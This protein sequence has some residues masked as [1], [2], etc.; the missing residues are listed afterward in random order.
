MKKRNLWVVRSGVAV[1][2]VLLAGG[3]ALN[4]SA[5]TNAAGPDAAADESF[6]ADTPEEAELASAPARPISTAK[7]LPPDLKLTP[8]AAEVARLV[9]SG[10]DAGVVRAFVTNSASTF[11]LG[12]DEI[13]YLNDIGV[14]GNI[15][16]AM[17]ERDKALQGLSAGQPGAYAPQPAEAMPAAETPPE[18]AP[19]PDA[20]VAAYPPPVAEEAGYP[21]FYDELSPYGSWVDVAGVGPCWQPTVVAVNP[22]W[23]PYCDGGHWIYSDCGWYWRSGYSW[24]W[25][26]FHYGR[27]FRHNRLGW[28]W[29]PD[30]VWGPSWVCW[31][32]NGSHCG[33]APLPPRAGFTAGVGIN[34]RGGVVG[35][36]FG[37]GLG[38]RSFTF[39]E[40]SLFRDRHLNQ[41]ALPGRQAGRIYH[42][43]SASTAILESHHRIINHGI[44]PT[45]VAAATH[46]QIHTVAIQQVTDPGA[47]G[48]RHESFESST[49]TLSVSRPNFHAPVGAMPGSGGK[50]RSERRGG[51]SFPALTPTTRRAASESLPLAVP[52]STVNQPRTVAPAAGTP[53]R[54]TS[55]FRSATPSGT[56]PGT[57]AATPA[58]GSQPRMGLPLILHGADCLNHSTP[59][60]TWGA[61]NPPAPSPP[62]SSF[63]RRDTSAQQTHVWQAPGNQRPQPSAPGASPSAPRSESHW[64]SSPPSQ[65][66]V[67]SEPQWHHNSGSS[68]AAAPVTHYSPAPAAAPQPAHSFSAPSF[69][70][71]PATHSVESHSAHY[72]SPAPA[73][74]SSASQGHSSSDHKGR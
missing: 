36:T 9:Q 68:P 73:A 3:G 4:L 25:A 49:R 67:R 23:R 55:F 54:P 74:S 14:P 21:V 63:T 43:T 65:P 12:V 33:W 45:R 61:A 53:Q 35:S 6:M 47:R 20:E 40:N 7:P 64:F 42:E 10:V 62:A 41:D 13:I 28:C 56:R 70:S 1:L 31:R 38:A 60:S 18:P 22:Y 8:Q 51:G 37:F 24:G 16:A 15:V 46:T 72:S 58:T 50:A 57:T 44:P 48:S 52:A 32:Y 5:Q 66:A 26:P 71:A 34:Y 2:G 17:M 27:W 69:S 30:T 29:R 19:L 59:G 11:N 39:V